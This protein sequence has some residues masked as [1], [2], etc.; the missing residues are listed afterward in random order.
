[1]RASHAGSRPIFDVSMF[2]TGSTAG[3][4]AGAG[5][6]LFLFLFLPLPRFRFCF[7]LVV[8]EAGAATS[9][10]FDDDAFGSGTDVEVNGVVVATESVREAFEA[11]VASTPAVEETEAADEGDMVDGGGGGGIDADD[12][13][14]VGWEGESQARQARRCVLK[15]PRGVFT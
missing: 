1:M 12:D 15:R 9:P 8:G 3:V 6:A 2:E 10:S 4:A 7:F 5:T 14:M 11:R 13:D